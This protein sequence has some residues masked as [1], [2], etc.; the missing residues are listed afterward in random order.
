MNNKPTDEQKVIFHAIHKKTENIIIEALA[1][2]GK[3]TTIVAGL[4]LLPDNT[5]KMFLAFNK[6]IQLELQE[7]LP[8]GVRCKTMHGLGLGAIKMKY[9]DSVEIDEFKISKLIKKKSKNWN[10]QNEFNSEVEKIVYMK[11]IGKLVDLCR[12]TLTT[13]KKYI[14]YIAQKY[15]IRYSTPKDV[16]RVLS[17]LEESM[18]DKKTIDFTDMVFLPAIDPKIWL[19]PQDYVIVDEI[20]DLN[21]AQQRM[22][23]KMLKKDRKTKI[24]TGRLIGVGDKN[25]SIYGFAGADG[26]AFEWFRNYPNTIILPLTHTFRCGVEIVNEAKKIVPNFKPME[27]AHQG[28]VKEGDVVHDPVEGDFV[29]CRKTSPLVTLFFLYLLEGKK[30]TIKGRDIGISLIE[31]INKHKTIGEAINFW[32]K[33]LKEFKKSLIKQGIINYEEHSGYSSMKDKVDVILFLCKLSNDMSDLIQKIEQIFSDDLEGIVLS[34]VHKVK[35][36]EADRVFIARP[37]IL[38]I[39]VKKTWQAQQEKNLQYVAITRARK[40][41][42][43]DYNWNDEKED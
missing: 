14:P 35:G 18:N 37:D 31:M 28:I 39:P 21:R 11:T 34:T 9:G 23:D 41:L 8:E 24:K 12:L 26:N 10:L 3:T 29:L 1:G 2:C 43:Y 19:F 33:E 40:E 5:D 16:K 22:I 13:N 6:H 36:L 20:Q 17:I 15:D 25:Q 38:P 30:A 27:N 32:E 7:K 42:I 4:T